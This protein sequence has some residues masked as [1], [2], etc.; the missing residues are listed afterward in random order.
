MFRTQGRT[1]GKR[2]GSLVPRRQPLLHILSFCTALDPPYVA[3]V[4]LG[5]DEGTAYCQNPEAPVVEVQAIVRRHSGL[6]P[7]WDRPENP[8]ILSG[9]ARL[10]FRAQLPDFV[11]WLCCFPAL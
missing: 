4:T 2:V 10:F 11:S 8:H 9:L 1:G 3:S 7:A 6:E 5:T